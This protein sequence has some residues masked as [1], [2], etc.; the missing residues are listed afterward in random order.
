MNG[1][2]R[3]D[4]PVSE[5]EESPTRPPRI[6]VHCGDGVCFSRTVPPRTAAPSPAPA[7]D[8][9]S[10]LT[11]Q[12]TRKQLPADLEKPPPVPMLANEPTMNPRA[13]VVTRARV[14]GDPLFDSIEEEA[15]AHKTEARL[16]LEDRFRAFQAVHRLRRTRGFDEVLYWCTLKEIQLI[17]ERIDLNELWDR[18]AATHRNGI[19]AD[20]DGFS[21]TLGL[22]AR[23]NKLSKFGQLDVGQELMYL[24]NRLLSAAGCN[25]K[26]TSVEIHAGCRFIKHKD[27]LN[28]GTRPSMIVAFGTHTSGGGLFV[29]KDGADAAPTLH[30]INGVPLYFDG[31][32]HFHMTQ[33]WEGGRRFS[34]A[35]Y[36]PMA[37]RNEITDSADEDYDSFAAR[38]CTCP[39]LCDVRIGR[40]VEVYWQGDGVW[41]RGYIDDQRPRG[42]RVE[43]RVAYDDGEKKYHVLQ[44][45]PFSGDGT[46]PT[47]DETA[48]DPEPFRFFPTPQTAR[49]L[50]I[51]TLSRKRKRCWACENCRKK[52]GRAHPCLNPPGA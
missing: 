16:E 18:A 17:L 9:P 50:A 34:L 15:E 45:E 40:S 4:P 33:P 24:C 27:H 25:T 11:C 8:Q 10:L 31:K 3:D 32:N 6:Q 41:Y 42:G 1:D 38:H 30:D 12:F 5:S 43:L 35:F 26:F 14:D 48:G 2:R 51:A 37:C 13:E 21:V 52:K 49:A 22:T 39:T 46:P 36:T 28:D 20:E 29:W 23:R 7:L 47:F 44:D 19:R